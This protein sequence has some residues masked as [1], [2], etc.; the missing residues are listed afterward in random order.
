MYIRI[1]SLQVENNSVELNTNLKKAVSSRK[2]ITCELGRKITISFTISP[3]SHIFIAYLP[4]YLLMSLYLLK[5][6]IFLSL[7]HWDKYFK[8]FDL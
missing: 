3:Q 5:G 8:H 1:F 7:C 6:V 4:K 2:R